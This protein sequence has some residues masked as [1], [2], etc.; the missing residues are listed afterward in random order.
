MHG[1]GNIQPEGH[2]EHMNM[3]SPAEKAPFRGFL[4]VQGP[5]PTILE[6]S[7]ALRLARTL[8][9][10][11]STG[12]V[13]CPRLFTQHRGEAS[14]SAE[15]HLKEL[16]MSDMQARQHRTKTLSSSTPLP[17]RIVLIGSTAF[18]VL[19]LMAVKFL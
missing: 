2:T 13:E 11:A 18:I 7:A 14:P 6:F 19:F 9:S 8:M 15:R 4:F 10:V 3:T 1:I 16:V 12:N 17:E 5:S